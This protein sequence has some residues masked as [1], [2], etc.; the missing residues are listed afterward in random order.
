MPRWRIRAHYPQLSQ[1]GRGRIIGLKEAAFSDEFHFQLCPDNQRRRVW[2]CPGQRADPAFPI[3]CFTGPQPGVKARGAI[4]LLVLDPFDLSWPYVS[5]DK[6]R[7]YVAC[8][9]LNRLT[10]CQ[11][12][13]WPVRLPDL[14]L[15]EHVW[16]MMRRQLHLSRNVDDLARQLE[17]NLQEIP[18][19]TIRVLY[20]SM[21]CSVEAGIQARGG[22][23]P[24]SARHFVIIYL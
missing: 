19:E 8:V 20:H 4:S 24:Y 11:T 5:E 21:P 3:A 13:P 1:F 6:A 15:I 18:Q 17:Q 23:T 12:L 7:I 14:S 22:S 2:R 16:D 9:A 10:A